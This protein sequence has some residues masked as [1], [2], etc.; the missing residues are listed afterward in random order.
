MSCPTLST[1]TSI[2]SFLPWE[3][4]ISTRRQKR[5]FYRSQLYRPPILL[6]MWPG[7]VNYSPYPSEH[8]LTERNRFGSDLS[9]TST[10]RH[11]VEVPSIPR[12]RVRVGWK[13]H[14]FA[15]RIG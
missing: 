1:N 2:T 5:L 7:Y 9:A 4:D 13:T 10:Y 6:Y 8:E 12:S 14:A 3:D 15:E 11:P